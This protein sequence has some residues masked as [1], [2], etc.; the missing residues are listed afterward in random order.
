MPTWV[1][2]GLGGIDVLGNN[3]G[4]HTPHDILQTSYAQWQEAWAQTL[5]V[6]L[7]G[8]ANV[9]WCA[10]RH[11]GEHGRIVNV[12]SRGAFRGE[13]GH[14]AYGASKAAL[15]SFGQSLALALGPRGIAVTSVAPGWVKTEMA[16]QALAGEQGERGGGSWPV[17][18]SG[19]GAPQ[20]RAR[21]MRCTGTNP[22][23]A[24]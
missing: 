3:A 15:I 11:M 10:V 19:T 21:C 23:T 8:A 14:P 20:A 1:A 12:A 22:V 13:P 2:A 24:T 17:Q 7:V 9:T 4:V 18:W 16:A 5:G 6:N